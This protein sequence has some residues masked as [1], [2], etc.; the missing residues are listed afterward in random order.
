MLRPGNIGIFPITMP[1]PIGTRR[2]GSHSLRI[3]IVIKP[4]PIAI[5]MMFCQA[6]LAKP[7]NCQN[8]CRLLIICSIIYYAMVTIGAP[9]ST[10]S[11]FA[12]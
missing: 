8:C 6:Q 7:V 9:S 11:P 10:E 5:I 1:N 2:R 3:A 12:T 4:I